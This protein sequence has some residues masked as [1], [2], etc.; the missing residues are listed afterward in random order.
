M[1]ISGSGR[2]VDIKTADCVPIRELK[3]EDI[4][5]QLRITDIPSLTRTPGA[6]PRHSCVGVRV[7]FGRS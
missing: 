3:A 4:E 1:S 6:R 5:A 2:R 7:R